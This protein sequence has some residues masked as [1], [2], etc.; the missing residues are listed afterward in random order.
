MA[1]LIESGKAALLQQTQIVERLAR[2]ASVVQLGPGVTVNVCNAGVWASELGNFLAKDA[3]FALIW[4]YNH[5]KEGT[6]VSVRSLGF[7]VS[8]VASLYGGGGHH[9]AA[10]FQWE[11]SI[12]ALLASMRENTALAAGAEQ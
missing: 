1:A 5:H 3:S 9:R 12:D 2:G 11:G 8:R 7:D 4:R 6:T 10:G